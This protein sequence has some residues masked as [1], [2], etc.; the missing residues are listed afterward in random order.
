MKLV[1]EIATDTYQYIKDSVYAANPNAYIDR[2]GNPAYWD[3][4][5]DNV[6]DFWTTQDRLQDLYT[7]S[8]WASFKDEEKDILIKYR[9][10][11]VVTEVIPYLMNVKGMTQQETQMFWLE[12]VARSVE[13]KQPIARF[14]AD[15]HRII[16]IVYSFLD[17]IEA[18]G[19]LNATTNFFNLYKEKVYLGT[20]YGDKSDGLMDF[21]DNTGG[22]ASSTTTGLNKYTILPEVVMAY[23]TAAAARAA[24]SQQLNDW[25]LRQTYNGQ[26][27]K[28]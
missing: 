11:D 1:K 5:V 8:G 27:I 26:Y 28:M 18:D 3:L 20:S 23:G 10:G 9:V 17:E 15:N 21:I 19:L 4:V 7:L 2:S 16:T 25:L 14:R 24:F 6:I 22:Y 12:N 13:K